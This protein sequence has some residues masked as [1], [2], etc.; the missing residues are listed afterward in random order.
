M[1]P[2]GFTDVN[3]ATCAV[4]SYAV[5]ATFTA[6]DSDQINAVRSVKG[7]GESW[8][9]RFYNAGAGSSDVTVSTLCVTTS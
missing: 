7:V 5:G 3:G 4:G 1:A 9:M 2:L 6:G 8:V